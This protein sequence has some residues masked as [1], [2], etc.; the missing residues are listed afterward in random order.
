M[1]GHE[2]ASF[3][4]RGSK[5]TAISHVTF[6]G[7]TR[8]AINFLTS[9]GKQWPGC[10]GVGGCTYAMHSVLF[11]DG[12]YPLMKIPNDSDLSLTVSYSDAYSRSAPS[13][14]FGV[15]ESVSDKAGQFRQCLERDPTKMGLKRGQCLVY[16]PAGSSMKGAGKSGGDIGAT[17]L[18]RYHD[19][20]L[21]STPLWNPKTGAFPCGA[22]IQGINDVKG[23]SC[24]DIHEQ[25]NVNVNGCSL[26]YAKP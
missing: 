15:S 17:I 1:G 4:L 6:Y 13:K 10:S 12:S 7:T 11:L 14:G 18:Y 5:N 25:L 2:T 21:T 16:V 3:T 20:A 26:P 19:G 24:F 22:V 8:P 23:D 9:S